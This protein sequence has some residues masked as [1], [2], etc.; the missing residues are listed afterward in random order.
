[1]KDFEIDISV[2]LCCY[3]SSSRLRPTL[4]HLAKQKINSQIKWEVILIDNNSNDNTSEFAKNIWLEVGDYIPFQVI[5]ELKP[6]LSNARKKGIVSANGEIL[7]FCDDDNWLEE[8]YIQIAY[9]LM[10]EDKSIGM[11]GGMG[12]EVIEGD[13]PT[14]F[15]NLKLSY[16]VG[17]QNN[18]DG[19]ITFK[20]GFVY[21]AGSIVRKSVLTAIYE[22]GFINQLT[23]RV[24]KLFV[25][26]GDNEIG[27][28]IALSG[29][30]IHYSSKLIFKHYLPENRL[31]LPYLVQLAKGQQLTCYKILC[32][33]SYLFKKTFIFPKNRC[34]KS[35]ST[36]KKIIRLVLD[37]INRKISYFDFR[38]KT[39]KLIYSQVYLFLYFTKF[40]TEIEN[41]EKNIALLN[42]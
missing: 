27:Y 39:T 14:W 40:K 33:E 20:K 3:N 42:K 21:G 28:M 41:V 37:F 32:Y 10:L 19:D 4:E 31:T 1:M 24:G 11:L 8:N 25:S 23:D 22:K 35:Y 13:K 17:P 12:N 9:D 36:I 30:K 2:V 16:A 29:F 26:G 7:I 34:S 18:E 15:E 38:L 5:P 6:G